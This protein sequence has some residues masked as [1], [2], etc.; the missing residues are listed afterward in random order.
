M[1]ANRTPSV[2]LA[3]LTKRKGATLPFYLRCIEA[4]DYPKFAI[5]LYVRTNNNTDRTQAIL[6]AWLSRVRSCYAAV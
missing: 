1:S 2:L 5:T 4:L 6:S 3:I